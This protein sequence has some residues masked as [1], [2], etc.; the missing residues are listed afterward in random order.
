MM[1]APQADLRTSVRRPVISMEPSTSSTACWGMPSL[2]ATAMANRA[3][4]TDW[5]PV[6]DRRVRICAPSSK[7]RSKLGH[8]SSPSSM[9]RA[10]TSSSSLVPHS[11]TSM[12]A[13]RAK[14]SMMKG[15]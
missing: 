9:P 12:P 1:R 6:T 2:R 8:P 13:G 4:T 7:V 10:L 15:V 5:A 3:F 11:T 14:F